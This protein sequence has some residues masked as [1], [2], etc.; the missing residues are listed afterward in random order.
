MKQYT[1]CT[2]QN[3]IRKRVNRASPKH[4]P[5]HTISTHILISK[6]QVQFVQFNVNENQS[7]SVKIL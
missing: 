3:I 6:K 4:P 7:S 5:P 1:I 2:V